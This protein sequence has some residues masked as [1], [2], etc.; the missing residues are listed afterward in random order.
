V[1]L[2]GLAAPIERSCRS[3]AVRVAGD[4]AATAWHTVSMWPPTPSS[5]VQ[6]SRQSY[7]RYAKARTRRS[8]SQ[9]DTDYPALN[10]TAVTDQVPGRRTRAAVRSPSNLTSDAPRDPWEQLA[11]GARASPLLVLGSGLIQL[12]AWECYPE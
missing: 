8:L 6:R 12:V 10:T 1:A 9:G 3:S 5:P 2:A 11:L 7:P 4:Y